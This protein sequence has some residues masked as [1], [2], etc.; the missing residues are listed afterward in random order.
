MKKI[1]ILASGQGSNAESIIQYAKHHHS[2]VV[3]GVMSDQ[4]DAE[5]L[6]LAARQGVRA[7]CLPKHKK[8]T[9]TVYHSRLLSLVNKFNPDYVVLA[10][11]MRILPEP[12]LKHFFDQDIQQSKVIN[13]HPSLLPLYPG[14]KAYEKSFESGDSEYGFTIHYVDAGMDT[15]KIIFQHKI[16]RPA[17]ISF[18]AYRQ[19]GIKAENY[20]YPRVLAHLFESSGLNLS[21][22]NS[23]LSVNLREV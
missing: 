9:S 22:F 19:M 7:C 4:P 2:Y 14:L 13:I 21:D 11:Y 20:F 16:I 18:Q 5:V 23:N 1:I 8:E 10:G 12:F 15:G 17:E 3:L 6:N